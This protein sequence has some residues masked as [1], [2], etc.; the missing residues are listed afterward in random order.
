MQFLGS[1]CSWGFSSFEHLEQDD[2]FIFKVDPVFH[3]EV[4]LKPESWVTSLM[5]DLACV[6]TVVLG[7]CV[8]WIRVTLFLLQPSPT[9][10][11]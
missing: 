4:T 5:S 2:K 9:L 11:F 3:G 7:M 10:P 6:T 8:V 1:D